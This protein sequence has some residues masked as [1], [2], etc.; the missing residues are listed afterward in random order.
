VVESKTT[1]L[2]LLLHSKSWCGRQH[3]VIIERYAWDA[4]LVKMLK[5]KSAKVGV[6]IIHDGEYHKLR[7]MLENVADDTI[8]MG[9]GP[10]SLFT[11]IG[12]QDLEMARETGDDTL[13][14]RLIQSAASTD[15]DLDRCS[16]VDILL[17][18][19]PSEPTVAMSLLPLSTDKTKSNSK[20]NVRQMTEDRLTNAQLLDQVVLWYSTR[21]SQTLLSREDA[22]ERLIYDYDICD[23]L[24]KPFICSDDTRLNNQIVRFAG[25]LRMR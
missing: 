12:N 5:T 18:K 6:L 4:N 3:V 17:T 25:R 16:D 7:P 20:R 13:I 15:V 14:I 9:R 19:L 23:Q 2:K 22:L 1:D 10:P 21:T 24:S 8:R 11:H